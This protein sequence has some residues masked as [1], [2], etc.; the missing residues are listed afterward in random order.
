MHDWL[1]TTP[2][3]QLAPTLLGALTAI[4][5]ISLALGFLLERMPGARRIWALPLDPGQLK[6]EL[7]GNA[8]FLLVQTAALTVVLA[9]GWPRYTSPGWSAGVTTFFAFML[10]FQLYYYWLHRLMHTRALV[11]FHRWHHKSRVTTP[12][13]GQSVSVVEAVAWAVGYAVLPALASQVVPISLEG[14]AAYLAFN[15]FGNIVGHSNAELV[16]RM[17]GQ[18][19]Q[20]LFSNAFVFHSLHHARWTGH[21]SFQAALMDRVFG[22]E[23][24][25]WQALHAEIA[26]GKPLSSLRETR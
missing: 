17:P 20:S 5:L 2:W 1:A 8:I 14:W 6:L 15:I 19:V 11:R 16:P 23:W 22:T 9:S 26:A 12:L 3:T 24:S 7:I 4:T 10:G 21:Y 13:S 25:D 18:R